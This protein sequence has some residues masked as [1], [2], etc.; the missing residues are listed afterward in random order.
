MYYTP[1][2]TLRGCVSSCLQLTFEGLRK[3]K[4]IYTYREK[5]TNVNK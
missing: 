5:D 3:K 2:E 4:Y 1:A